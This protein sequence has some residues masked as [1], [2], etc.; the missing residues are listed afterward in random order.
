MAIAKTVV[1]VGSG[2]ITPDTEGFV[3]V[4]IDDPVSAP[5]TM[6]V[7]GLA[8]DEFLTLVC[9]NYAGDNWPPVPDGKRVIQFHRNNTAV[10]LTQHG[11]YGVSGVVSSTV[12]LYTR[13]LA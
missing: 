11:T 12:T 1:F 4:V 7:E 2:S 5:K 9:D 8:A 3:P 6:V 10:L 13:E